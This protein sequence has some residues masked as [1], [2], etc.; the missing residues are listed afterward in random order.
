YLLLVLFSNGHFWVVKMPNNTHHSRP[1]AAGT[2]NSLPR[3]CRP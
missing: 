2:P 1:A 3:F